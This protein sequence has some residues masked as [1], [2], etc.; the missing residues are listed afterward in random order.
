MIDPAHY[1][2]IFQA[3]DRFRAFYAEL[4][5]AV[6]TVEDGSWLAAG[7]TAGPGAGAVQAG[8][9]QLAQRV[10]EAVMR[11]VGLPGP[12]L[13]DGGEPV[14]MGYVMAALADEVFLQQLDWPGRAVWDRFLLEERLYGS[15]IAG[16]RL[17][18]LARLLIEARATGQD[19]LVVALMQALALGFRGRYRAGNDRGEIRRLRRQLYQ[20]ALHQT[21]PNAVEWHDA[22]PPAEALEGGSL[23]RVPPLRPWVYGAIG[24]VVLFF[25]LTHLT[26]FSEIGGT[27][28]A[29]DQIVGGAR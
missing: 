28:Q 17:F 9:R 26:W 15:R 7:V 20:L 22:L 3:L 13:P 29:A 14:E 27:L 19:D 12:R 4:R 5:A 16:E 8:A 1:P 23:A 21:A 2:G 11:H 25:A 18:D 10:Q 24:A 6:A